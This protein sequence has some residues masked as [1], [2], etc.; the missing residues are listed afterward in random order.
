M[1]RGLNVDELEDFG[2]GVML[3]GR[4]SY[5]ESVYPPLLRRATALAHEE[6]Q[7]KPNDIGPGES[8]LIAARLTEAW[9]TW[10]KANPTKVEQRRQV[11]AKREQTLQQIETSA[12]LYARLHGFGPNAPIRLRT[13]EL[14]KNFRQG[15]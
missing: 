7:A 3:T 1:I 6:R 14:D 13:E 4:A 9:A 8:R 11:R 12:R 10:R 15:E 5:I 2:E